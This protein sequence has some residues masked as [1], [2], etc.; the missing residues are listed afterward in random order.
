[1]ASQETGW[2]REEHTLR[3]IPPLDGLRGIAIG[4][5]LLHHYIYQFHMPMPEFLS[6]ILFPI[7]EVGWSG[8]DLFFV[9]SGFLIGGILVDAKES[10]N[11]YRTF[12]IRRA[13][14]ILPVYLVL[15]FAGILLMKLELHGLQAM[16]NVSFPSATWIY[17]LTF[18]QNFYFA[19]HT[20]TISYLQVTWS[21]AV[22]EQFYLTLPVL[23]RKLSKERLLV[24][25]F[26]MVLFVC[27]L[28]SVLYWY[29][30]INTMQVY[31][32]PFFR[33]DSLFMG[34]GCAL[35]LR[36]QKC[37]SWIQ[38]HPGILI[39]STILSGC[40]FCFMDHH[41]WTRNLLL[42]TVGFTVIALFYACLMMFV[43]VRP[44]GVLSRMFSYMPLIR[45]GTISYCVYLIHGPVIAIA[46]MLTRVVL[47]PSEV[48]MWAATTLAIVMILALAWL[49]WAVFESRMVA[50]GHQFTY[51]RIKAPQ[52]ATIPG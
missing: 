34:V 48:Q 1:M 18:A 32:L 25:A 22:E 28:R 52:T 39:A 47:G 14:R 20:E 41:L 50:L 6:A 27:A 12:Y 44:Q 31:V 9:L 15:L 7:T 45:L 11:Y 10:E 51:E 43:L 49:S 3:R 13:F 2:S 42:H 29:G 38:R 26:G 35:L 33:F 21:L 30:I 46:D 8:V 19:R 23:V 37:S 36:D 17:Y 24:V 4:L 16:K 5:V 40:A